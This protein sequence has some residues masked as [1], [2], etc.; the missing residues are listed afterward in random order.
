MAPELTPAEQRTR[1]LAP[2]LRVVVHADEGGVPVH[3]IAACTICGAS[4]MEAIDQADRW[5]GHLTLGFLHAA[6]CQ[7]PIRLVKA[8]SAQWN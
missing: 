8:G 3:V 6:G 2:W 7:V 1:I 4:R 5:F